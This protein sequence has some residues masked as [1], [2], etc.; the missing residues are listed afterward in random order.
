MLEE[1]IFRSKIKK[2][3]FWNA[4]YMNLK[5]KNNNHLINYYHV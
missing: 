4:V 3:K 1:Q 2:I 5:I